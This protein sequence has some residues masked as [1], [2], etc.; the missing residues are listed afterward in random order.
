MNLRITPAHLE[1][2]ARHRRAGFVAEFHRRAITTANGWEISP[3]VWAD[4]TVV[5]MRSPADTPGLGDLVHAVAHPVA[6]ALDA[7][8]GTNLSTCGSCDQRREAL[9]RLSGS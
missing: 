7:V 6:R 1:A 4:L 9:N 2:A 5:Y 3:Q 8:V